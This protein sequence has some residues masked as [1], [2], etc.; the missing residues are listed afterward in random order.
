MAVKC[1]LPRLLDAGFA[2]VARLRPTAM[3]YQLQLAG[4]G[5][6]SMTLTERDTLPA[7]HDWT[8]LYTARGSIGLFR[9]TGIQ[10]THGQAAAV[11]LMHGIDTLSDNVWRVRDYDFSGTVRGFLQQLLAQQNRVY[12]QLGT[13][14]DTGNYKKSGIN[15]TRLSDLLW[16]LVGQRHGYGLAYD[17]STSPWTLHLMKLPATPAAEWRLSRNIHSCQ[18]RRDDEDLCT[19]LYCTV[20]TTTASTPTGYTPEDLDGRTVPVTDLGTVKTTDTSVYT[21]DNAE[22]QA[23]YGIIEKTADIDAEDVPDPAAWARQFLADRS[24]PT[25]QITIDGYELAALTGNPWDA[26]DLGTLTRCVLHDTGEVF[27]ERVV[28][29]TYPDPLGEPQHVTVELANRLPKFSE[30]LAGVQS[31]ASSAKSTATKARR[32]GG[33]STKDMEHWAMVVKKAVEAL[34][35]TGLVELWETGIELDAQTGAKLYSLFQGPGVSSQGVLQVMNNEVKAKASQTEVNDLGT[36]MGQAE[37]DINGAKAQIALKASQTTVDALGTRVSQAEIDIDGAE[38][39]IALKVAKGDVS[40]QLAVECGNVSISGGNLVVD[41]YIS[42][43][44]AKSGTVEVNVL[45]LGNYIAGSDGQAYRPHF[46]TMGGSSSSQI[47]SQKFLGN[48]DLELAHYHAITA[49]ESDGKIVLT[50]GAVQSSEGT[51]NFNIADTKTYKDGVSAVKL[52]NLSP[53]EGTY[54]PDYGVYSKITVNLTNGNTGSQYTYVPV[55]IPQGKT[56]TSFYP[57]SFEVTNV[58]KTS[59]GYTVYADIKV[60]VE[61]SDGTKDTSSA[62]PRS[63][64]YY[65]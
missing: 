41:G 51:A 15:Y 12:W 8:E 7:M 37:V 63:G 44:A 25:L 31:T 16:E 29:I 4:T 28:A 13:C 46:I 9:V 30:S 34:D 38:A 26:F 10:Q 35:G 42:A 27:N 33:S 6:A 5:T 40:T 20:S 58:V 59:R 53:S 36:R 45:A 61:Y 60:T 21:Y 43:A 50:L 3:S 55:T 11:T 18:V 49:A 23:I 57:S 19:R 32:G 47:A 64:S 65:D 52:K 24:Q 48:G 1:K 39:A 14:Q 62:Y 17:F 56:V 2:E 22:A 54:Y